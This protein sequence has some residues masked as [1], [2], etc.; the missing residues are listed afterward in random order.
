M[1]E[2]LALAI[3]NAVE[4]DTLNIIK[5]SNENLQDLKRPDLFSLSNETELFQNEKGITIKL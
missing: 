5:K 1:Q 2:N 3:Q 4:N